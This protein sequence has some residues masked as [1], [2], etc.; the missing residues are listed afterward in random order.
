MANDS[1]VRSASRRRRGVV[2]SFAS[3]ALAASTCAPAFGAPPAPRPTAF[4]LTP[5]GSSG[6][7]LLRST[8]GQVV[9]GSVLVRNTSGHRVRVRLRVADIRNASNGNAD[10]ITKRPSATGR[11]LRLRARSVRLAPAAVRRVRYAVRIPRRAR[12][13]AHYGGIVAVDAADLRRARTNQRKPRERFSF[14]RISRQA[15]P[16]TIRLPGPHKRRLAL[17]SVKF[18]VEPAGAGLVL[19]LRPRGTE[20]IQQARVRLRVTSGERTVLRHSGT[21]GQLFPGSSLHYR[22]ALPQPP[23]E[24]SYRV[25][26]VIRPQ[27]AAR[28]Y[29]NK[30]ITFSAEKVSELED[31]T[32]TAPAAPAPGLPTWVWIAL[33]AGGLAL[34]ASTTAL[35][36]VKRRAIR[37]AVS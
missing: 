21:L 8:A 29:I 11:W 5:A 13:G 4:A 10:Y 7:M 3:L 18:V 19:G 17:R 31:E 35:L 23:T 12:G 33:T 16:L 37:P 24:G 15:L 9:R 34:I 20:L 6:S 1:T 26:G 2:A 22:I 32:A 27:R 14:S 36:L 30:T 25:Q 28:V